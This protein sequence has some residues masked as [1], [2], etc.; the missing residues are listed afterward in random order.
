MSDATLLRQACF[1]L[2][3]TRSASAEQVRAAWKRKLKEVHPD[4]G[5]TKQATQLATNMR[6]VLLAWIEAGRPDLKT[7]PDP[8]WTAQA[9]ARPS[10]Q[11]F[12]WARAARYH[13]VTP[14]NP[15]WRIAW[16][17]IVAVWAF[18]LLLSVLSSAPPRHQRQTVY[19]LPPCP[20]MSPLEETKAMLEGRCWP[21]P[22][23][24]S[25]RRR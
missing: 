1:L 16:W 23:A 13:P 2:G 8:A 17:K 21:A 9:R 25:F 5:G 3:V 24:S 6:D 22:S 14:P 7:R 11:D 20:P 4:V 18:A 10:A 19:G 15:G 12:A